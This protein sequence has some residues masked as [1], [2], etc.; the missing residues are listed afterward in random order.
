MKKTL[1]IILSVLMLVPLLSSCDFGG[2]YYEVYD[3]GYAYIGSDFYTEEREEIAVDE[4]YVSD[5]V[6][7]QREFAYQGKQYVLEYER[8]E[9]SMR[10]AFEY[11]LYS[12]SAED[13]D[14]F[15]GYER[16]TDRI[17]RLGTSYSSSA[18][19]KLLAQGKPSLADSELAAIIHKHKAESYAEYLYSDYECS[20]AGNRAAEGKSGNPYSYQVEY[21]N[22]Y[23]G[24]KVGDVL[25]IKADELGNVKNSENTYSGMYDALKKHSVDIN[26]RKLV[27]SVK[28]KMDSVFGAGKYEYTFT[29]K[30]L[31]YTEEN[32][33]YMIC[34]AEV[35]MAEEYRSAWSR[36]EMFRCVV[37]L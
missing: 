16:G 21:Y 29:E 25:V 2:S 6:A 33:A 17:V 4:R 20:S 18:F 34:N 31:Y 37:K 22:V 35:E 23:D 7:K 3:T 5:T 27:R 8:T 24:Y 12:V 26:D 13:M 11:D 15:V 10:M 36:S 30:T 1:L 9:K 32:G 19:D 14:L 28:K